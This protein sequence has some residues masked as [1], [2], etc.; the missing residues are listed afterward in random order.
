MKGAW[1]MMAHVCSTVYPIRFLMLLLCGFLVGNPSFGTEPEPLR[2][3]PSS[4]ETP[5]LART[6]E[7]IRQSG[8]LVLLTF[9]HQKSDFS[10]TNVNLGAMPKMA[11]AERFL[12]IDIDIIEAFA[13]TLG[14]ELM[15]RPVSKPRYS[16][17]IPDLLAGRGDLIGSSFTITQE[18]LAMVD[19]SQPYYEVQKVV[20]TSRDTEVQ[21]ASQL[22]EMSA[23]AAAGSS[24]V[25]HL[26]ELGLEPAQI[27]LVDFT[28]ETYTAL[29]E[30]RVDFVLGDSSSAGAFLL[31]MPNFHIALTLPGKDL[32]GFALPKGS[33]LLPLLDSFLADSQDSGTLD[34]ILE[35]NLSH[36]DEDKAATD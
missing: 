11:H 15:V 13:Q 6:L 8:E 19:F 24:L 10:R 36:E 29:V 30:D 9:P 5:V 3:N 7:E 34:R 2:G 4:Q 21:D 17:L 16:A 28:V 12:G 26:E 27:I 20:V 23:A 25:V 1:K 22:R 32:Y 35:H 31:D 18:R 33:E 14:V